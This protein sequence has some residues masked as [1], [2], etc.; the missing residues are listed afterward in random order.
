MHE[1][2]FVMLKPDALERGLIGEIVGRLERKGLRPKRF[3][4][5]AFTKE[6]AKK[7]YAHLVGK[8]FYPELEA[9]ITRG[10]V[11]GSVWEGRDAIEVV[12]IL[13]G[14]TDPAKAAAGTIRG[15]L[16]IDETENLVH[17]SDSPEAVRREVEIFFGDLLPEMKMKFY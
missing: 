9:Y 17:A 16:A 3:L 13:V 12:R 6:M 11:L 14:N 15:D 7:H 8:K 1:L 2:T 10:P 4:W 5:R